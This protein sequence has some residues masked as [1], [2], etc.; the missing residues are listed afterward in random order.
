[1]AIV[2]SNTKLS[3]AHVW[4]GFLWM[5]GIF[6]A[7]VFV[8]LIFF[9]VKPQNLLFGKEEHVKPA[10]EP[11]ALRD[12]IEDLIVANVRFECLKPPER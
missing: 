1:V 2:L 9:W 6:V 3:E 11:S 4:D 5:I 7:I 10:L 12:Q 8:A